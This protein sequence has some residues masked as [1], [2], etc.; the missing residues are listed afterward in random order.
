MQSPHSLT[1]AE[2]LFVFCYDLLEEIQSGSTPN[3]QI[4]SVATGLNSLPLWIMKNSV[5]Y[6]RLKLSG[7]LLLFPFPEWRTEVPSEALPGLLEMT[8]PK[9]T[10]TFPS[11]YPCV[12][13]MPEAWISSARYSVSMGKPRGQERCFPCHLNSYKA[14][15]ILPTSLVLL[16]YSGAAADSHREIIVQLGLNQKILQGLGWSSVLNSTAS[17]LPVHI[18]QRNSR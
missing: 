9:H 15:T 18:F 16:L 7:L 10:S 2:F 11:C 6:R 4:Q 13:N 3:R 8:P 1:K 5:R 14:F 12:K 17:T